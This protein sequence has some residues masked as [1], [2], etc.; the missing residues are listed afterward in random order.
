MENLLN[1]VTMLS[2]IEL[3]DKNLGKRKSGDVTILTTTLLFS[4]K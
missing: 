3:K 1:R 4:L 2:N